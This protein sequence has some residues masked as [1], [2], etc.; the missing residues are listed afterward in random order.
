LLDVVPEHDTEVFEANGNVRVTQRA[1]AFELGLTIQ[2]SEPSH[3]TEWLANVPTE[4]L[5]LASA[6]HDCRE[7]FRQVPTLDDGDD[8]LHSGLLPEGGKSLTRHNA[9]LV[10]LKDPPV[11]ALFGTAYTEF[12]PETLRPGFLAYSTA[13]G[14][15][16]EQQRL[17]FR[18]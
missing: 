6:K 10:V 8:P 4:L 9:V 2:E 14:I 11:N 12:A 13:T 7:D 17:A 18:S 5:W 15:P 16:G 1:S 3:L